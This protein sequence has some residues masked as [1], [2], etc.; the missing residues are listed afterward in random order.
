[1]IIS[2][3]AI[4]IAIICVWL[5]VTGKNYHNIPVIVLIGSVVYMFLPMI[6]FILLTICIV[7]LLFFRKRKN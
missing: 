1:M 2:V 4:V 3:A 5:I 6:S 7:Y